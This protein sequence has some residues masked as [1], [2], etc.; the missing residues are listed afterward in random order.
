[1]QNVWANFD[2][3]DLAFHGTLPETTLEALAQGK[4]LA[5]EAGEAVPVTLNGT[6]AMIREAGRR[7]GYAYVF[8]TGE[9]GE[10]WAVMASNVE[11][12][13][14]MLH[15]S[16]RSGAFAQYGGLSAIRERLTDR[17]LAFGFEAKPC[18]KSGLLESISRVDFAMDFHADDFILEPENIVSKGSKTGYFEG[19]TAHWSGRRV[20]GVTVGK[21]PNRQVTIYDKTADIVA[22]NKSYWWD[23]W[24]LEKYEGCRVWRIELRAGKRFLSEVW[25]LR[26][27]DELQDAVGDVMRDSMEKVRLVIP[28]DSNVTRCSS[29]P[30]WLRAFDVLRYGIREHVA[31][32][33]PGAVKEVMKTNFDDIMRG[34]LKGVA[35]THSAVMGGEVDPLA[36]YERIERVMGEVKYALEIDPDETK[37]A[38]Q[39]ARDRYKLLENEEWFRKR[40]VRA[41][42]WLSALRS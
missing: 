40:E 18:P 26:T 14:W 38:A 23:V 10:I 29:A 22:K 27:L 13:R 7:G 20:T 9:D 34:L 24:G 3:L 21:M 17:L 42:G 37:K 12:G 33:C 32:L 16:V 35:L 2:G 11:G 5:V 28:D 8:D 1:M 25:N 15:C 36:I 31:G 39:K 30:L 41:S 19:A 4:A 6:T